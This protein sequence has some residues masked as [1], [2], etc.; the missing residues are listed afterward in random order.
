MQPYPGTQAVQRAISL[1]FAFTDEHPYWSVSEL[2]QMVGLNRTTTYRLLTALESLELIQQDTLTELYRLGAGAIVLG[3][4]AVR[5]NPLR[6]VALPHLRE[7]AEVS[8]ETV[9]L[10]VLVERDVLVV[11]EVAGKQVFSGLQGHTRT[12]GYRWQALATSSGRVLLAH[13]DPNTLQQAL[14][15]PLPAF[16]SAT[17]TAPAL[18]HQSVQQARVDGFARVQDQLEI[19]YVAL[20]APVFQ[21]D[22]QAVAAVAIS[23]P[24]AR[25]STLHINSLLSHLQIT[26]QTISQQLGFERGKLGLNDE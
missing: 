21:A 18:L 22:G 3:G 16:T 19:G 4:R 20:A 11:E 10:E 6:A 12:V 14:A 2:A 24:S 26:A 13:S 1:L 5:V 15:H 25:A 17:I 9:S 23:L 8:G 7:L